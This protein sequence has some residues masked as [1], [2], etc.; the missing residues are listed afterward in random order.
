VVAATAAFTV[1]VTAA[2]FSVVAAAA[3][4]PVDA[5]TAAFIVV[6]ATTSFGTA[7]TLLAPDRPPP[8]MAATLG[9]DSSS[10]ITSPKGVWQRVLVLA[11][12][13]AGFAAGETPELFEIFSNHAVFSRDAYEPTRATS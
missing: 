5:A 2:A 9:V 10:T 13:W 7:G 6:A 3:A 11:V 4:C 1:V 12:F 8:N